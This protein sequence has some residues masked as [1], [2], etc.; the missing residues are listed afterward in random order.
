MAIFDK[1]LRKEPKKKEPTKAATEVRVPE[2]SS[3]SHG[4]KL[5]AGIGVISSPH[6]TEKSS[7]GVQRGTYVF[8]VREG[9][10]KVAIRKAVAERY[11]VTVVSVNIVKQHGKKRRVGRR[12][13]TK[14]GFTKAVVTIRSGDSIEIE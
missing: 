8:R 7:L 2:R 5:A 11:G 9:S 13:G 4:V 3:H 10:N 6:I 1:I 12:E 14:S